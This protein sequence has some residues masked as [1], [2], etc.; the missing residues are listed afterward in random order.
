MHF[1]SKTNCF[2]AYCIDFSHEN[3]LVIFLATKLKPPLQD[4]KK[5]VS[6]VCYHPFYKTHETAQFHIQIKYSKLFLATG[7]NLTQIKMMWS[8]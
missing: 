2:L 5:K 7:F 4:W 8:D 1:F 6:L 3:E